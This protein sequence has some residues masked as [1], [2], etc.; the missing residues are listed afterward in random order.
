[1][2]SNRV[3][4]TVSNGKQSVQFI[5]T[6]DPEAKDHD[7]S[8]RTITSRIED[9]RGDLNAFLAETGIPSL[10]VSTDFRVKHISRKAPRHAMHEFL[11][12]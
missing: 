5:S 6:Y 10:G 12:Y 11:M 8:K 4:V 9:L 3:L 2:P 7:G 1:M